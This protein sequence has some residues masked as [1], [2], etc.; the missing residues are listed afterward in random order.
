MILLL[1]WIVYYIYRKLFKC[2][3]NIKRMFIK[4]ILIK[5]ACKKKQ[6]TSI[7]SLHLELYDIIPN[8]DIEAQN[9]INFFIKNN[10]ILHLICNN[11]KCGKRLDDTMYCIFDSYYCSIDCQ[12]YAINV[13]YK[14]W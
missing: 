14:Y 5:P 7:N 1:K 8:K 11:P 6:L 4:P 2:Y 3:Y 13:I 9:L 12:N 10:Y